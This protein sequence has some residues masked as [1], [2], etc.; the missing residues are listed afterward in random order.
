MINTWCTNLLCNSAVQHLPWLKAAVKNTCKK[1]CQ[2]TLWWNNSTCFVD[3]SLEFVN[4]LVGARVYVHT[5][6][7]NISNGGN[8]A[9]WKR[10]RRDTWTKRET[11]PRCPTFKSFF[12]SIQ[13]RCPGFTFFSRRLFFVFCFVV[14]Q[15]WFSPW[16]AF[17]F[18][19]VFQWG[20]TSLWCWWICNMDTGSVPP[21]G[22]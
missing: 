18:I 14:N 2:W 11:P 1:N 6:N 20:N 19:S 21:T 9:Q 13:A 4:T 8:F 22:L 10:R 7:V 3:I 16:S 15:I 17:F 12:F 5:L